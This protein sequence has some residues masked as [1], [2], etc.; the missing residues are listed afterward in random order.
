MLTVKQGNP[1][2]EH[3]DGSSGESRWKSLLD[4]IL[5]SWHDHLR[6][7]TTSVFQNSACG[8]G[9]DPKEDVQMV[10]Y[11]ACFLL[12]MPHALIQSF[13]SM[14]FVVWSSFCLV[15][16][17]LTQTSPYIQSTCHCRVRY[18]NCSIID[19]ERNIFLLLGSLLA[20]IF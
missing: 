16:G 17:G 10:P 2:S 20:V 14:A 5:P 19:L 12:R 13:L 3:Q 11:C 7:F 6:T 4:V 15:N 8:F 1:S 18:L 9:G